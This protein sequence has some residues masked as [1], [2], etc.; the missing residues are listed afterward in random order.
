MGT[1]AENI[2]NIRNTLPPGVKLI[3][4]SKYKSSATILEAYH[5]GQR[6]FGENKVQELAAKAPELPADIEWHFIGHLQTNKVRQ[7]IPH[8]DV[9]QSVDS[10]KLLKEI[11]KEA[12]KAEKIVQ[13]LLQFHIAGEVTKFGL[14]PVEARALLESAEYQEMQNVAVRGVMGMATFTD[15]I[16]QVDQEF[17]TLQ[18]IFTMLKTDYFAMDETFRELSMGM[19]DDYPIALKHGSTMVRIGTAI[20]GGR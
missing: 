11:N 17:A 16:P 4:V 18:R 5:C 19:S 14:N 3:A 20:F 12:Q 1:L 10:L 7:L 15:N 13:C 2:R 9:I 6:I 8:V